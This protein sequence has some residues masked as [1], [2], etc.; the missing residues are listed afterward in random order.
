MTRKSQHIFIIFYLSSFLVLAQSKY[1]VGYGTTSGTDGGNVF[2]I[3]ELGNL[4]KWVDYSNPVSSSSL[5][6][7]DDILWGVSP[8]GGTHDYGAI[9]QVNQDGSNYKKIIDFD[10]FY[11]IN[12]SGGLLEID[13][14]L[15]GTCSGSGEHGYGTIY[16]ISKED[17]GFEIIHHFDFD[18]GARPSRGLVEYDGR[19]WGVTSGGGNN[20]LVF[21][22]DKGNGVIYSLSLDGTDFKLEHKFEHNDGVGPEGPLVE[23]SGKLWGVATIGGLSNDG[24]VFSYDPTT[25]SLE[26]VQA[27]NEENGDRPFNSLTFSNDLIWGTTYEGGVNNL[28]VIFQVDPTDNTFQLVKEF[29]SEGGSL[30]S[31]P[32][33]EKNGKLWSTTLRGGDD[34]FGVLFSIN[35]DGSNYSEHIE[36]TTENGGLGG[37][38]LSALDGELIMVKPIESYIDDGELFKIS[39]GDLSTT[40]IPFLDSASH[41][42]NRTTLVNDRLY[43]VLRR[44][45]ATIFSM[46]KDG[47]DYQVITK[48]DSEEFGVPNGPLIELNGRLWGT[49]NSRGLFNDGVLYSLNFDGSDLKVEHDFTQKVNG[50]LM[51]SNGVLFGVAEIPPNISNFG[52]IYKYDPSFGYET[53]YTF[54][55]IASPRGKLI[56]YNDRLWGTANSDENGNG[57]IFSLALDGSDFFVNTTISGTF[58]DGG[59]TTNGLSN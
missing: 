35:T 20:R 11:G 4:T 38:P 37:S 18:M 41:P 9:F 51:V 22:P 3:D 25:E 8:S 14:Y 47:S 26:V 44:G 13:G 15:I 53:V 49:T 39:T 42:Q 10:F 46:S 54:T 50:D 43:G 2:A 19:L 23:V 45:E 31:Q 32:L 55:E 28:G 27:F 48:L 34:N 16:R 52:L 5:T 1:L 7:V 33:I 29:S 58:E 59:R 56:E 6:L 24:T 36:G 21:P 12:P 17:L 40:K 30:P 57:V